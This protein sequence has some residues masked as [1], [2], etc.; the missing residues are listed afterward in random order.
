MD[1][2]IQIESQLTNQNLT[3][4]AD[5]QEYENTSGGTQW[6]A[7]ELRLGGLTASAVN[8][9]SGMRL[10]AANGTTL[11]AEVVSTVPKFTAASTVFAAVYDKIRVAAGEKIKL[12]IE[13]DNAGDSS[14]ITIDIVW[15]DPQATQA[16]NLSAGS[17]S[18]STTAASATVT[19][20]NETNTYT[21]TAALDLTY[22]IV[23]D[24]SPN[25]EFYY[26]FS[27]GT[28]GVPT[29]IQWD[30][31]AQSQGDS[32]TIKA[33]NW[34]STWEQVGLVTAV[35]GTTRKEDTW[36]LTNAHVG[37]GADDGK[38]R[39]QVTSSDGTAF[40]TDRIL[41]NYA[42]VASPTGYSQGAVWLDLDD[43]TAGAVSDVN[44]VADLPTR[45]IANART[46]MS[47]KN[48]HR[49]HITPTATSLDLASNSDGLEFFGV[50]WVLA[51][52]SQS[53]SNAVFIGASV[54]GVGTGAVDP[55]FIDCYINAVTLPGCD[56]HHCDIQ[57]T[58]TLSAAA[59]YHFENCSSRHAA[60]LDFGGSVGNTTVYMPGWRG[61]EL[62]IQNLGA[63]G[64]DVLCIE[65]DGKLTL[66][67]N[68]VAGTVNVEGNIEL[69]NNGSGMT[70]NDDGRV[71]VAQIN[72][73]ADA[74]LNT[75]I[76]GTPTAHSI[77]QRVKAIDELTEASGSGD[78]AAVLGDT[79]DLQVN[80]GAW[81]TAT[82]FATLANVTS[83]HSTTNGKIDA[84]KADTAA[85][86][87][88]TGTD[89]V[90]V[91]DAS[92]SGYVL[93]ATGLNAV[94]VDGVAMPIAFQY[95]AAVC[96]GKISGAGTGTETFVGIDGST[97][98]AVVTVD[99]YGN[100]SSISYDP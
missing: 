44:G 95:V 41:C 24:D 28:N 36:N 9:T 46:I 76:P 47:A 98:R 34:P 61:C 40:A 1:V 99:G 67:A 6:I 19:T 55:E 97:D 21:S 87:L 62:E 49:L 69:T 60:V 88:D 72:A 48:L 30:G 27:V 82:G 96:A 70:V 35:N 66:N 17:A 26:E 89:G 90:V 93:A 16:Q 32:Y 50:H 84:V 52:E 43:G 92:K 7:A 31:Y 94:L 2:D 8:I 22:H 54:S 23:E 79:N 57:N 77:N 91:A 4:G 80:Q 56:F 39:L 37:T 65:G 73:G 45:T 75:A 100:R 29:A 59:T 58:V 51:L 20:G 10:Y 11:I 25:T 64:T 38:V 74:A 33:L 15:L 63:N 3:S 85:T 14:G 71:D 5:Y 68:C 81:A 86:L 18:I 78:L 53:I 83:A 42:V 13:S 12:Y